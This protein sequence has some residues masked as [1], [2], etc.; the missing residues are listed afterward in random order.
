MILRHSP[1]PSSSAAFAPQASLPTSVSVAFTPAGR[2]PTVLRG[3]DRMI[4][5]RQ[6]RLGFDAECAPVMPDNP[7]LVNLLLKKLEEGSNSDGD[8]V[9]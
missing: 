4:E 6:N 2:R 1:W 3:E 7:N 5:E 8:G 9:K